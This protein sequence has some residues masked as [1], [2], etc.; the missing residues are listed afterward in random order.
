MDLTGRTLG[1]FEIVDQVGK[2]GMAT[3]Y[4]AYQAS[5]QRHVALKVLAPALAQDA[6]LVRR[7]LREAQSAAALHHPNV[8]VIHDVGSDEDIHYIVAEYLEGVT[9]AKLLDATGALPPERV[10]RILRQVSDALD[11]AH[12]RG[13]VHRDIKPSNIMVDPA[14]EDHVTLMDFGLVQVTGESRIT[15][16]GLIMGTPDYMSPEQA[17]GEPIDRRTDV[18]SLGV[19][20]YHMLTGKVPFAKPTPHAILMAHIMEEPPSMSVPG[21][22]TSPEVEAVVLKSMA[23]N[24]GDR[25]EWAGEMAGDL[26]LA[27]SAPAFGHAAPRPA[28]TEEPARRRSTTLEAAIPSTPPMS[29]G[30]PQTPPGAPAHVMPTARTQDAPLSRTPYAQ[31]PPGGTSDRAVRPRWVWP[32]LGVAAVAFVAVLAILGILVAPSILR[33][34]PSTARQTATAQ[35]LAALAQT[36]AI[37]RFS[38]SPTEIVE[39]QSVI[40]EWLVS[41]VESVSIRPDIVE[42]GPSTGS[43]TRQPSQTTTYEL[44]LP[45]GESRRQEVTVRPAVL[46]PEIRSFEITPREQ[47][48]EGTVELSWQIAGEVTGVELSAN[49]STVS[50]LPA[51]GTLEIIAEETTLF[52]LTARNGEQRSSASVR[53]VVIE[54]T[55]TEALPAPAATSTAVPTETPAATPT[56]VPP[57]DTPTPP[58]PTDTPEPTPAAPAA[59]P[60]PTSTPAPAPSSGVLVSFERWGTWTRGEQPYGEFVQTDEQ[61]QAGSYAARLSYD[62]PETD[63]DFVVFRQ[64]TEIGGT[65]NAISVW[66]YG[67]GSG[68]FLNVWIEDAKSQ[69]W[70]VHLGRIGAAGWQQMTGRID[71]G[72]PWPSGHVFGPDNGVIDYPIRFYGIVLDRPAAGPQKGAVYLDD[73]SVGQ[74]E[75]PVPDDTPEAGGPGPSSNGRI[76][77]TVQVGERYSLYATDPGWDTMV[78]LGDTDQAH[79]TCAEGSVAT[80]LEGLTVPLRPPER[81]P[82]AGT[83]DSCPSPD[84]QYKVNTSRKGGDYQVTLWRISDNKM[85]E[86]I[87][88][89]PLNIH[90]G[91]NWSPDSNHFLFTIGQ[92]VYRADVGAAGYRLVIPFKHDTWPLQYTPDGAY[93]YYLKPISGAISDVFLARPDGTDERNLTNAPIAVKLCPRWR[94]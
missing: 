10:L 8:V 28:P 41:G 27:L 67:D 25:Y 78:K 59:Q 46:P 29:T 23:K 77:F 43:T 53:L 24:P 73:L 19:T 55:P 86:A 34:L 9:L 37:E 2:G 65:P 30:Q 39:G 20:T 80:T 11:Y 90:P 3:V 26:E 76:V 71:A 79:S 83:V 92:G 74:V 47:V 22:D 66:V 38:V 89:G 31:T 13:Y 14:C 18:Y 16:T 49:S 75:G 48:R 69:V 60:K 93:V 68:H 45:N 87:Y 51:Q 84:G 12:A 61:V 50:A 64:T 91:I 40:I 52:V 72:R 85:L 36:P 17:K 62:F 88:T 54:P 4:K 57:T 35:A 58:L 1:Q 56:P 81:C 5:L 70:S 32:V 33:S 7:F 15:R 21:G 42:N 82:V 63:Q 44:I 94:E 6:D